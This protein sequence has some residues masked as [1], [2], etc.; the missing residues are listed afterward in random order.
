MKKW[1]QSF[2]LC[3]ALFLSGCTFGSDADEA[4]AKAFNDMNEAEAVYIQVQKELVELE[5]V[6]QKNFTEMM[7][8]TQEDYEGLKEKVAESEALLAQRL[9]KIGEEEASMESAM[10][11]M[12][13][14]DEAVNKVDGNRKD[15]L[16]ALRDTVRN[17]YD[18]HIA[19]AE[20]YRQLIEEQEVLYQLLVTKD[21]E[22]SI[23]E[24][25]VE[26][27]NLHY[28]TVKAAIEEFNQE[29]ILLNELKNQLMLNEGKS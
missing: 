18:A 24:G 15:R 2:V 20:A 29:T 25:Q 11:F 16:E 21:V 4:L 7:V 6:E 5:Q 27:V 26:K 13:A 3:G 23:L 17:R 12:K 22:W 14:F 8:L 10:E 9:Q 1:V 19:F 28:E